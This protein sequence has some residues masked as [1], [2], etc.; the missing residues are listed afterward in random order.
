[1][2]KREELINIKLDWTT[3]LDYGEDLRGR[4]NNGAHYAVAIVSK[5]HAGFIEHNSIADRAR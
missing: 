5:F 4:I 3:I 2:G 1:M